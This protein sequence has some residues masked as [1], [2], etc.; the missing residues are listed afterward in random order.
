MWG[1]DGSRMEVR[2]AR[3]WEGQDEQRAFIDIGNADMKYVSLGRLASS[4]E[5]ED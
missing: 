1:V 2:W 5:R 3:P 4:L